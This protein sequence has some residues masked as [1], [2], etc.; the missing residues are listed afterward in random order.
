M[1][2]NKLFVVACSYSVTPKKIINQLEKYL[3]E[4]SLSGVIVINNSH[5]F[6][7][8]HKDFLIIRG[9][10]S[11]FEFSAYDQG[12]QSLLT[13]HRNELS[14]PILI[15]NDTLF[16]KHNT[17]FILTKTIAYYN[18]ISR[19]SVCAMAGRFDPY[20]NICFSSPWSNYPGYISS[21]CML[22][23]QEA[24]MKI[25]DC[26]SKLPD[27]FNNNTI[28]I[29]D[30]DWGNGIEPKLKEF[31]RSHLLDTETDTVWYQARLYK[32]NNFRLDTKAK[33]VFME[34][35]ISGKVGASGVLLS[36]IPTWKGRLLHFLNEQWAKM[37]R[38]FSRI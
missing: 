12:I 15:I 24:G 11:L 17:K 27:N 20:N 30:K 36:I 38:V 16:T 1:E 2:K 23:N 33:C 8:E 7:F 6:E 10:N 14:A 22:V 19:I 5:G 32:D 26:Y 21:F 25:L 28:N 35:Y 34:H 18:A 9:D 4:F 29:K 31:I 37:A 13:I 3:S